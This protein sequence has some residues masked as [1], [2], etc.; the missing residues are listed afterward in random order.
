MPGAQAA[1][2]AGFE[3]I[4][5]DHSED[6]FRFVL[7]LTRN[8]VVAEDLTS[9]TFA[10]A[11]TALDRYTERG[12]PIRAWLMT[13]ARNVVFDY[14]KSGWRRR[15]GLTDLDLAADTW[16]AP[17]STENEVMA[18]SVGR[19]LHDALRRLPGR[20]GQCLF[21][22]FFAGLSVSQTASS[23]QLTVGATR[24]MQ[25]RAVRNLQAMLTPDH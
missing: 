9:E 12:K 14:T 22:R 13:I 24:A 3:V 8:R 7:A 4:Y 23:L 2:A 10:R 6:V 5:R 19:R 17:D 15:E 1:P 21:L 25:Y 18:R 11:Y 20:Q 16:V